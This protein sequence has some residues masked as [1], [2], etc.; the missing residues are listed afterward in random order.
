MDL[1]LS[2]FLQYNKFKC[3]IINERVTTPTTTVY[4]YVLLYTVEG[5][6][7]TARF[8]L[9]IEVNTQMYQGTVNVS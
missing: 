1:L 9:D 4:R 5:H 8:V 3:R 2:C 7:G 6:I